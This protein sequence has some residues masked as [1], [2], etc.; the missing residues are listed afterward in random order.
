MENFNLDFNFDFSSFSDI[1]IDL[2]VDFETKYIKP[3]R[4]K[5]LTYKKLKYSKAEKLAKELDF[6]ALDRA[7]VIVNGSF[8]FGDFIEAFIVENQINVL[9]MTISTLSYSKDNIDSLKNLFNADYIQKLN[10]IVSD[11]FFSHEKHKLIKYT[12]DQFNENDFQL[13]TA[14]TH[15]KI[16][17]FK[18]EGNKHI[19]IHG[20]VNLR[21][22]GNIE[23]FVIED[24]EELY[25]FNKEYQDRIIEKYKTINKTIRSKE[26][27]QQVETA[28]AQAQ[29][30]KQEQADGQ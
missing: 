27:W 7:F 8:I 1:E 30:D 17:Q 15:C 29:T 4:T 18:T 5:K 26:L 13:A 11:Y 9:E 10:I 12:Y 24:N 28:G 19:V 6:K 3:P 20:S 16:C 22:S 2:N 25:N 21:S 23:Q 14:G